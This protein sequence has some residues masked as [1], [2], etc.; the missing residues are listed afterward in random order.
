MNKFQAH[1]LVVD[2]DEGIRELVKQFL[3]E[4][5]FLITTANSAEDANNSTVN[6]D[7]LSNGFKLRATTDAMNGS[8][9][10]YV[11]IA[12]AESPFVSSEGVPTTA[13]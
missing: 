7:F 6:T 11:Y 9:N 2:D 12:F 4:N 1:I 10:E 5:N 8:G 13:E 3:N